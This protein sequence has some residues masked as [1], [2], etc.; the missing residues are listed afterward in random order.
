MHSEGETSRLK[1]PRSG[2]NISVL[3]FFIINFMRVTTVINI[4]FLFV[5][6]QYPTSLINVLNKVIRLEEM[7]VVILATMVENVD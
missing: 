2:F 5:I 4:Q 6:K 1:E 3:K 7:G